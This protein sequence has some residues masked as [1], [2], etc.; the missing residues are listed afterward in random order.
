M[1]SI[2]RQTRS[3][4]IIL[5]SLFFLLLFYIKIACRGGG[6]IPYFVDDE[7][8]KIWLLFGTDKHRKNEGLTDFGGGVKM[9]LSFKEGAA[10]EGHEETMGVFSGYESDPETFEKEGQKFFEEKIDE[11]VRSEITFSSMYTYKSYFV[12]VT[13]E[14]TKLGGRDK[15]IKIL[16][17]TLKNLQ[18]KQYS[19]AYREKT[20]FKWVDFDEVYSLVYDGKKPSVKIWSV[21]IRN[22]KA[23]K[24]TLKPLKVLKERYLEKKISTSKPVLSSLESALTTLK[25]KLRQLAQ[26]LV[27]S[28]G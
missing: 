12:N 23:T 15:V 3:K 4:M 8:N 24:D 21:F 5:F 11:T 18:S 6:V 19:S 16:E 25:Q 27:K 7:H 28:A 20:D 17:S 1:N 2:K 13:K 9:G 26:M 14:T 22:L 10:L